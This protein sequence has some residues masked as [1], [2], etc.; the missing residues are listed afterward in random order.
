[1]AAKEIAVKKYV[2]KLL[3]LIEGGEVSHLEWLGAVPSSP[4]GI[5]RG[6]AHPAGSAARG[7]RAFLPTDDVAQACGTD[8]DD[9]HRTI[10][11]GRTGGPGVT[12]T[13]LLHGTCQR[14]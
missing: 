12:D 1:V 13:L 14:L 9:P 5:R 3:G 2:V 10:E 4:Q 8:P 6:P 7:A 11:V